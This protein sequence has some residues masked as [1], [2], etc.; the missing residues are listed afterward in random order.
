MK[1]YGFLI[2]FFCLIFNVAFGY[3]LKVNDFQMEAGE[4]RKITATAPQKAEWLFVKW[5]AVSGITL[6]DPTSMMISF[7]MPANNVV[8]KAVY[9]QDSVLTVKTRT[10]DPKIIEYPGKYK[11]QK[12]IP[13][14]SIDPYVVTF[15][16][17]YT[18]S[19]N[20]SASAARNFSRWDLNGN[21]KISS[22]I[23]NPTT[24]TYALTDTTLTANYVTEKIP[25]PKP[26]R[27]GYTFKSW[28]TKADGSGTTYNG[29]ESYQPTGNITLYAQWTINSYSVTLKKNIAAGGKVTGG[30][31]YNYA[32]TVT[33]K[34]TANTGYTFTG[35]EVTGG[36]V[37]LSNPTSTTTTFTM[38]ASNVSITANFSLN[39]WKVETVAKESSWGTVTGAGTYSYGSPVTL[40]ASNNKGY[41][42]EEWV[43]IE[44][45]VTLKITGTTAT[46]TMPDNAV[47]VQATFKQSLFNVTIKNVPSEGGSVTGNGSHQ[48]GSTVTLTAKPNTGYKFSGWEVEDG[49]VE[50]SKPTDTTTTFTM[51]TNDVTIKA[52]FT[53]ITYK[54]TVNK[55][56]PVS[57]EY[58]GNYNKKI[59]ITA[60]TV[61][62]TVTY[63]GNGGTSPAAV[64]ATYSFSSW[65][66]PSKG[67]LSSSKTATADYTFAASDAT[68]AAKYTAAT[69]TLPSTTRTGYT[70]LGWATSKT[71]T[72]AEYSVGASY[73]VTGKTTLYAVWSINEY[74]LTINPGGKTTKGDYTESV[75]ITAPTVSYKVTY[76]GNGGTNPAA[77][78]A[79][80]EFKAWEPA[81]V[82]KIAETSKASTSY[83]FGAGDE[84]IKATY[85]S[86]SVKLPST[87]QTGH[88]LL[89]WATSKTATSA[90]YPV[91]DPY[92]P[93]KATT[94]YAVW[95]KNKYTLTVN[96]DG[97]GSKT[98]EKEYQSTLDVTA[99]T[100]SYTVTYDYNYDGG[101]DGTDKATSAFKEWTLK[102]GGSISSKTA[103]PTKYTFG[104]S[105]GSL[106]ASYN[107][108]KVTLP[109]PTR[110]GHVFQ[111]WNTDSKGNGTARNGGVSFTPE[112][113]TTLYAIWKSANYSIDTSPV[114]YTLT[115]K[116]AVAKA[117][118]GNTIKVYANVT[119]NNAV[120]IP[121]GKNITLDLDGKTITTTATTFITV[122]GGLTV[123][124]STGTINSSGTQVITV[125][126]SGNLTVQS[127]NI[128]ST[129]SS[130]Y[131]IHST[132]ASSTIT[133][134]V[135]NSTIDS[136]PVVKAGKFGVY[137]IG[138]TNYYDGV[139]KGKTASIHSSLAGLPSNK[140]LAEES[141]SDGY[142]SSRFVDTYVTTNLTNYYNAKYNGGIGSYSTRPYTIVD[143]QG[144]NNGTVYNG[145]TATNAIKVVEDK[146][147]FDGSNDWVNLGR[148]DYEKP[149]VEAIFELDKINACQKVIANPQ[150]GG[151]TL[152]I[153]SDNR[154]AFGCYIDKA[155]RIAY[156][157]GTVEKGRK[158]HAIG[159][160]D[161]SKVRLYVDGKLVGETAYAGVVSPPGASTVLTLGTNPKGSAAE[162]DFLYGKIYMARVYNGALNAAQA[163]Q[164]YEEAVLGLDNYNI[165]QG[166]NL[167]NN[168]TCTICSKKYVNIKS[169]KFTAASTVYYYDSASASTKTASDVEVII[170]INQTASSAPFLITTADG[171]ISA[172]GNSIFSTGNTAIATVSA[173]G[174]V[175][176]QKA[177]VTTIT[178]TTGGNATA[179]ATVFVYNAE[180]HAY[181]GGQYWT[182][183]KYNS[184]SEEHDYILSANTGEGESKIYLIMSG[185][186]GSR[187]QILALTKTSTTRLGHVG[188]WISELSL[189]KKVNGK[190]EGRVLRPL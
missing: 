73:T 181:S 106:Q 60:P 18:N 139:Y 122:K 48:Y 163:K 173:D 41:E 70:L 56:G 135:N 35:W 121:S 31:T 114:T 82:G 2:I 179:T 185:K 113:D 36:T 89:G 94:L 51:P 43:V 96:P 40:T 47:K 149:T 143:L 5:E 133:L 165:H 160:Y 107:A 67:T 104:A 10:E 8:L 116:E 170:G 45:D 37:K 148:R 176:G 6:E 175:T 103:N 46:F 80:Y 93:S 88:K 99:P 30:G 49:G 171:P 137:S 189:G 140:I 100:L 125:P 9:T 118:S 39:S 38:P 129:A 177:G 172:T 71:A 81:K 109:T 98:Y 4:G 32:A 111:N 115:L 63:D 190:W 95:S 105:N 28:N 182:Y 42:F 162:S 1:K 61:E 16:H 141:T 25:L 151:Y 17:N 124:G 44:G 7:T 74:T 152:E 145:G 90:E 110:E 85:N 83:T 55:D 178:A 117:S 188:R 87:E 159:T 23:A 180:Y 11:E 155:Y 34:A 13:A 144:N 69:V 132:S 142:V 128:T 102:G 119:D 169:H 153:T 166:A 79:T 127:G 27:T 138:T 120:E 53:I 147:V 54:L 64:K 50:L 92:T 26:T 76:D 15:N 157:P 131:G 68:I 101:E 58:K 158:Y 167:A 86:T 77:A 112:G 84:T 33:L 97:P 146:M 130:G 19:T 72:S 150:G 187:Y 134:G 168:G 154:L 57:A 65:G 183:A 29:G 123:K 126:G 12:S 161:G 174:K 91:G 52:N 62:Y 156:M 3:T 186:S 136:T 75:S 20:S 59:S 164:N 22:D 24:Y 184:P 14:P 21:G 108:G 66:T 78:T